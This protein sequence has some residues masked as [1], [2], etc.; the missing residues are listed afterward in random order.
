VPA[1]CT[2]KKSRSSLIFGLSV[3]IAKILDQVSYL[4]YHPLG[5][6]NCM[7]SLRYPRRIWTIKN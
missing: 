7:Y 6:K 4:P 2:G 1:D 5:G 3:S